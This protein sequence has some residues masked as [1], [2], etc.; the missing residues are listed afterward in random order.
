MT[1]T[2]PGRERRVGEAYTRRFRE[3]MLAGKSQVDARE[4]AAA[5]AERVARDLQNQKGVAR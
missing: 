4:E 3:A 1:G 2:E 5:E